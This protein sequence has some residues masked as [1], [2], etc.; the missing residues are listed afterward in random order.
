MNNKQEFLRGWEEGEH[1]LIKNRLEEIR[2]RN[3]LI[4]SGYFKSGEN[5]QRDR[6]ENKLVNRAT[7]K[8]P[9]TEKVFIHQKITLLPSHQVSLTPSGYNLTHLNWTKKQEAIKNL[10]WSKA[11]KELNIPNLN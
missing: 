4:Q 5:N 1:Q 11:Q 10:E 6:Q 3:K 9:R 2:L 8:Y 7:N